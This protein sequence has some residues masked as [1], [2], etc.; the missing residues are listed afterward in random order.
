MIDRLHAHDVPLLV[1]SAGLGNVIQEAIVQQAS[2][3]DNMKIISNMMTFNDD[4]SWFFCACVI[5][6]ASPAR[7][8]VRQLSF[9]DCGIFLRVPCASLRVVRLCVFC[10]CSMNLLRVFLRVI[11]WLMFVYLSMLEPLSERPLCVCLRV[12]YGSSCIFC[13]SFCPAFAR[14]DA[15]GKGPCTLDTTCDTM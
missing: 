1:F 4:V 14:R 11:S 8:F 3:H 9:V 6:R 5:F 15:L 10:V 13:G 12:P 7:L 2:L